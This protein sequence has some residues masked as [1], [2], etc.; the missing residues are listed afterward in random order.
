V[1]P[2]VQLIEFRTATRAP[3]AQDRERPGTDVQM[4]EFPSYDAAME[5]SNRP[6]TGQFAERLASLCNGTPTFRNLDVEC[7]RYVKPDSRSGKLTFDDAFAE[8]NRSLDAKGKGDKVA[9]NPK[10]EVRR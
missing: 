5:N 2:F 7:G 4:V 1:V 6:A 8:Q 3:L 10:H 9:G